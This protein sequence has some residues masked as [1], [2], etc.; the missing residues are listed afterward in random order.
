MATRKPDIA[1]LVNQSMEGRSFTPS[2]ETT[3]TVPG[4]EPTTGAARFKKIP[5]QAITV[6]FDEGDYQTLQRIAAYKGSTAASLVR[7]A[8]KELIRSMEAKASTLEPSA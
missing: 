8:V 1:A 5:K 3:E 6:R 4:P 7:E 2:G